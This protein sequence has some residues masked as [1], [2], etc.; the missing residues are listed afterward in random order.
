[1]PN[2]HVISSIKE[3]FF[4]NILLT[5]IVRMTQHHTRTIFIFIS[6]YTNIFACAP[7]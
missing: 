4:L 3:V 2:F 5:L 6:T 1:M 7:A